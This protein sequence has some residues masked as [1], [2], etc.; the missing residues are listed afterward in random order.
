[1]ER[2]ILAPDPVAA[3]SH[4]KDWGNA[5]PNGLARPPWRV[6]VMNSSGILFRINVKRFGAWY[7]VMD[8]NGLPHYAIPISTGA[9]RPEWWSTET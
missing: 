4:R 2:A 9:K 8:T 6:L 3:D 1:M 5:S 7:V